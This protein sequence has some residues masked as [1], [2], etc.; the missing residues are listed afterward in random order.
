MSLKEAKR[1]LFTGDVDALKK[2]LKSE[3]ENRDCN[4][5][6]MLVIAFSFFGNVNHR[7]LK[8]LFELC[9]KDVADYIG[10]DCCRELFKTSCQFSGL[11]SADITDAVVSVSYI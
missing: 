3:P 8:F 5:S 9:G 2:Q 4:I 10:R 6:N 7:A 11:E 1:N